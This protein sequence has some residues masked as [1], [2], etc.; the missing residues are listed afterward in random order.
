MGTG[1]GDICDLPLRRVQEAA[2]L[3]GKLILEI[4]NLSAQEFLKIHIHNRKFNT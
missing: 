1:G 4:K 3:A 2:N